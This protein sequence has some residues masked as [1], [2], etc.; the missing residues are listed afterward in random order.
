MATIVF[1]LDVCPN[2]KAVKEYLKSK[3]VANMM[4]FR[5]LGSSQP[6]APNSNE[7]FKAKNRRIEVV[8]TKK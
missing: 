3:G 7:D 8:I 1:T 5:G 4:I 6:I 2:C